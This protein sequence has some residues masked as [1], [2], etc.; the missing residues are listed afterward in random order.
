MGMLL[1]CRRPVEEG[2][3]LE[4]ARTSAQAES[5]VASE[6]VPLPEVVPS[7]DVAPAL[8]PSALGTPQRGWLTTSLYKL[9]LDD[10][11]RCGGESS[12]DGA[13]RLGVSVTITSLIDGLFLSP[14]DLS[15]EHEGVILQT[16]IAPKPD[17]ACR[18]L[19]QTHQA[20]KGETTSGM[21]VFN[22]PSGKYAKRARLSF[23]PTRWGGAPTV[24]VA[25]PDCLDASLEDGRSDGIA[26]ATR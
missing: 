9:R 21:V 19:L 16:E 18:R 17:A 11:H 20:K 22:L 23:K 2:R 5:T 25:L 12:S 6:R 26:R 24:E 10:V 15:L 14:R 4:P 1:Q 3:K 7:I 8:V 13:V